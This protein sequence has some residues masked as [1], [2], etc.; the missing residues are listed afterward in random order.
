MSAGDGQNR[1]TG[2][3]HDPRQNGVHAVRKINRTSGPSGT[4]RQSDG[5]GDKSGQ[6][7]RNTGVTTRDS[8]ALDK[9]RRY[10]NNIIRIRSGMDRPMLVIILVLV[11]LGT[12]TVFSAS[13]PSALTDYSDGFYYVKKQLVFALLGIILMILISYIPYNFIRKFSPPIYV[14]GLLL[15]VLVLFVEIGRAHV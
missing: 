11:A 9:E 5:N 4:G 2:N 8:K 15:L 3:M 6:V 1:N 7:R 12:L 10:N 13:Y 14:F